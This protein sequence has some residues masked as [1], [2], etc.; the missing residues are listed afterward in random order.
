MLIE[1]MNKEELKAHQEKVQYILRL[2]MGMDIDNMYQEDIAIGY[3][4]AKALH[5]CAIYFEN[6][7]EVLYKMDMAE[8][9]QDMG[10]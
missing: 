7:D 3:N 8:V 4:N 10:Y 5:E 1:N 9:L 6:E 2:G